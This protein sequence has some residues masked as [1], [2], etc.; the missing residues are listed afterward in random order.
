MGAHG[1]S[2]W[3]FSLSFFKFLRNKR[4]KRKSEKFYGGSIGFFEHSFS[5]EFFFYFD[6]RVY[7]ADHTFWEVQ[8]TIKGK[9]RQRKRNFYPKESIFP[10]TILHSDGSLVLPWILLFKFY[11]WPYFFFFTSIL[12]NNV[13][14]DLLGHRNRIQYLLSDFQNINGWYDHRIDWKK[15]TILRL[16]WSVVTKIQRIILFRHYSVRSYHKLLKVRIARAIFTT[17]F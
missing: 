12:M 1:T 13:M 9:C 14:W 17:I 6:S 16:L 5:F 10:L 11:G 4:D 7:V 8:W 15:V 2:R 3:F